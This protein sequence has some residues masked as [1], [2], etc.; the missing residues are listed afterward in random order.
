MAEDT[1][2]VAAVTPCF[3]YAGYFFVYYWICFALCMVLFPFFRKSSPESFEFY[4]KKLR[5][6]KSGL[7][8]DAQAKITARYFQNFFV[9]SILSATHGVI[10][11]YL[12]VP[13]AWKNA[14]MLFDAKIEST[15]E[16]PAGDEKKIIIF[17]DTCY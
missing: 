2:A 9:T 17:K 10:M 16:D 14:S 6:G 3:I 5:L 8:K 11:G 13:F 15:F 1:S 7:S 4:S 12:L